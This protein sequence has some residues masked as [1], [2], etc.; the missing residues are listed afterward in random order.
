MSALNSLTTVN[1]QSTMLDEIPPRVLSLRESFGLWLITVSGVLLIL[2]F[3]FG[4]DWNWMKLLETRIVGIPLSPSESWELG[5]I[6]WSLV[7]GAYYYF[8]FPFLPKDHLNRVLLAVLSLGTV[9]LCGAAA[10]SL[11]NQSGMHFRFVSAIGFLFC[12][13]DFV[14]FWWHQGDRRKIFLESLWVADVPM[15]AGLTTLLIFQIY[16]RD[17]GVGGEMK[18]FL[19]G[20]ISFQLIVSNVVFILCQFGVLRRIWS[21]R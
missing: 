8:T 4:S 20:A 2:C 6:S 5:A 18:I 11:H 1:Q 17:Y 14:L 19:A 12:I 16:H 3:G 13:T 21:S 15:I 9:T 10:Y 7:F